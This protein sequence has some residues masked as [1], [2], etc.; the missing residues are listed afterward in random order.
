MKTCYSCGKEIEIEG[1]IG[2]RETCPHCNNDLHTCHNCKFFAE[3][4]NRQCQEPAALLVQDKDKYNHCDWFEFKGGSSN[5]DAKA[6]EAKEKL[7]ALFKP[8]S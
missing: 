3:N 1:R 4:A 2:L 6:K 7:E 8:K 5:R